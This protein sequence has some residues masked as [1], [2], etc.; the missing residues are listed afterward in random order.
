MKKLIVFFILMMNVLSGLTAM[1][2]YEGIPLIKSLTIGNEEYVR[3]EIMKCKDVEYV[4]VIPRNMYRGDDLYRIYVYLTDNRYIAF[5]NVFLECFLDNKEIKGISILL[6]QINEKFPVIQYY[7][8]K[9]FEKNRVRYCSSSRGGL[10]I[11]QIKEVFQNIN[12]NNNN[13]LEI[14]NNF[15]TIYDSVKD[16]PEFP[17]GTPHVQ[18]FDVIYEDKAVFPEEFENEVPFSIIEQRENI[19]T[20]FVDKTV[21]IFEERY[22]F[23]QMPVEKAVKEFKY[24]NINPEYAKHK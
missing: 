6:W 21:K 2:S 11:S 23:Y 5:A 12:F 22:K 13:I 24:E 4:E 17:M 7:Y 14:I 16:L 9:E 19:N 8:P 1:G 3:R 20:G 10:E 15:D 18:Y